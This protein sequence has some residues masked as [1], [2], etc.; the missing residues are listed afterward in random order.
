MHELAIAQNLLEVVCDAAKVNK[1]NK[2]NKISIIAGELNSIVFDAL[3]FGFL[4]SSEGTVAEKAKIECKEIPAL[5][6][7][8]SCGD[9]YPW[10]ECGYICPKC[11]HQGGKMVQGN[12]LYVD[13]IEGDEEDENE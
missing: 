7:C 10:K 13:F 2:V 12:E 3:E 6:E 11:S 5:I 8:E 1:I 9:K 4:V